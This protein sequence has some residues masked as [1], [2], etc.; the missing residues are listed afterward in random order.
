MSKMAEIRKLPDQSS[1]M[2]KGQDVVT[3]E[4]LE[5]SDSSIASSEQISELCSQGK[6]KDAIGIY[7]ELT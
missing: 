2:G 7:E 6:Y 3:H 4:T 5:E 1:Q